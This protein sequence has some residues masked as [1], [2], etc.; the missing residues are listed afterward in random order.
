MLIRQLAVNTRE[1]VM[2]AKI[3]EGTGL[4]AVHPTAS[5]ARPTPGSQCRAPGG[6]GEGRAGGTCLRDVDGAQL[7]HSACFDDWGDSL[8]LPIACTI[9][10]AGRQPGARRCRGHGVAWAMPH[11]MDAG[12]R[13]APRLCPISAPRLGTLAA[14]RDGGV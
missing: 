13:K 5:R 4:G 2:Q 7:G 10:M 8:R 12:G 3:E 11:G 1:A 6:Q 14:R 9:V